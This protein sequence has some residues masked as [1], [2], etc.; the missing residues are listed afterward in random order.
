MG[1]TRFSNDE[2]NNLLGPKRAPTVWTP[3]RVGGGPTI[4][5]QVLAPQV[6]KQLHGGELHHGLSDF[7]FE[8]TRGVFACR[9]WRL[10]F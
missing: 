5:Q 6:G 8:R 4:H 7:F 1:T 10:P 9:Q 2:V 3:K